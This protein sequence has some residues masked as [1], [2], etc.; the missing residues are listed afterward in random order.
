VTRIGW[1]A[2]GIGAV[3]CG[4]LL[5][6]VVTG[7]AGPG[8]RT[9]PVARADLVT[10][11][12][13]TGTLR[14]V[15]TVEVGAQLSGQ[16]DELYVDFNDPVSRGQ[17]LARL[18]PEVFEAKL[19]A[20]EAALESARTNAV[21]RQAKS[22]Q[23]DAVLAAARAERA[24]MEARRMKAR[25]HALEGR[26]E[27]E[28][29]QSLYERG[30]I[31]ISEVESA[32]AGYE[33]AAAALHEAEAELEVQ[34]ARIQEAE[35]SLRVAQAERAN[36]EAAVAR[37]R[38][39]RE[40]AEVELRRTVIRAPIDG[41]VVGREVDRGQSVAVGLEAPTLFTLA[42]DLRRMTVHARV[43]EADI[44][45]IGQGQRATFRVDA[46]PERSFR[47]TVAQIRK[48]PEVVQNVVTYVAVIRAEN[49][50][51]LLLP[52]MTAMVEI[53]VAE[54][55]A[56]LTVPN[57]AL[58][59]RHG[60]APSV[61]PAGDVAPREGA[62]AP[63]TVWIPG[64][65]GEPAPV[66]IQIRPGDDRRAEVVSGPLA[67]GDPVIVGRTEEPGGASGLEVRFGF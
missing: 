24:V 41:V 29:K 7:R 3:L 62:G 36:A 6:N 1:S 20:A 34:A 47:G 19:R 50:D 21:I 46:W 28:R 48:A 10:M 18:D 43:D 60:D 64:E 14:P 45:A 56:A 11:V 61:L 12:T 59:F 53:V 27:L 31:S 66:E 33:A 26:R 52:G 54:H 63:A 13:A 49:E 51:L 57:A 67:E 22:D 25:A 37:Q 65:D 15:V 44:G 8:W 17:P 42:Q 30:N 4:L 38:A 23:A 9:E 32:Q 5:A 16:I 35:A 39:L 55:A 2:I 40:E 58:R